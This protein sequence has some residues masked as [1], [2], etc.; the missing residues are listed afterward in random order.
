MAGHLQNSLI[1]LIHPFSTL[2]RHIEFWKNLQTLNAV[3]MELYT[4]LQ[5]L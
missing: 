5:R 2:H 1:V 3:D 4:G